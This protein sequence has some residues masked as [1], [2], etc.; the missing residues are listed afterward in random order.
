MKR[1]VILQPNYFPWYGYIEQIALADHFVHLDDVQLPQGRSF[2]KRVQI[3]TPE[4]I[5]WMTAPTVKAHQPKICDVVLA[6]GTGW[7]DKHLALLERSFKG[8]TYADDA[9]EIA[10]QA[11]TTHSTSLADLNIEGE[12]RIARYFGIETSFSR[13]STMWISSTSTQRL[14]DIMLAVGGDVYLTGHGARNYLEHER[15][16]AHGIQVEYIQYDKTPYTQQWGDFTPYV[17]SLD[18]IANRGQ[19]G[20]EVLTSKAIDW[21]TFIAS[22]PS[23]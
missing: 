20:R 3:K 17:S 19:A 5:K 4:G 18:L 11:L 9:L 10:S 13:S 12:E 6:Q 7:Q 21:R 22:N 14:V 23:S 15:F 1:V 16:E 8:A 2:T